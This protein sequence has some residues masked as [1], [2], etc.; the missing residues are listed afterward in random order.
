MK[1][2]ISR[3]AF[4]SITDRQSDKIFTE[5]SHLLGESAQKKLERSQLGAEKITFP[6]NVVDIRTDGQMDG[7]LLLESSFATKKSNIAI[8]IQHNSQI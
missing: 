4:C 1:T 3:K 5:Y 2:S 8:N 6:L 7:N